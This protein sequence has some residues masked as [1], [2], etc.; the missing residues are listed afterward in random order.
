[1]H[2]EY[3]VVH[4]NQIGILNTSI[5]YHSDTPEAVNLL[6]YFWH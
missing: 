4:R 3:E 1:M 2:P 5:S 6:K